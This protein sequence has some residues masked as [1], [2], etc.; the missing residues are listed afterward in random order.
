MLALHFKVK[1][2]QQAFAASS[3]VTIDFKLADIKLVGSEAN[4]PKLEKNLS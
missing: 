4:L 1:F 3:T 2:D